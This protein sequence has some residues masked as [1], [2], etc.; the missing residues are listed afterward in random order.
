MHKCKMHAT[1]AKIEPDPNFLLMDESFGDS[2]QAWLT[3][4]EVIFIF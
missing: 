2:V 3:Q 1:D 4:H